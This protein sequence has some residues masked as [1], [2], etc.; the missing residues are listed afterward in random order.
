MKIKHND[1]D[2][3]LYCI[4]CVLSFGALWITRLVI[5]AAIRHAISN[6]NA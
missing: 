6:D 3:I 1:T 4:F 2:T 5:S